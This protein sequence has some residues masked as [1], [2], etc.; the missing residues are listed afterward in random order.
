MK[1]YLVKRDGFTEPI[2]VGIFTSLEMADKA[3]QEWCREIDHREWK[4]IPKETDNQWTSLHIPVYFP[5]TCR[6]YNDYD[7]SIFIEEVDANKFEFDGIGYYC[8]N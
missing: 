3:V 4:Q 8:G 7:N 5:D 1:L 6:E 2:V